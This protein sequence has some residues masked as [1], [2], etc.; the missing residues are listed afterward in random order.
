MAKDGANRGGAHTSDV[1]VAIKRCQVRLKL[2]SR[3]SE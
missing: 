2:S 1:A 3:F